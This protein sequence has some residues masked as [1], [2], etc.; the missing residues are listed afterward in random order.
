[1]VSVEK[2]LKYYGNLA[3]NEENHVMVFGEMVAHIYALAA[4]LSR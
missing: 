1:M 4:S 3:L 2:H